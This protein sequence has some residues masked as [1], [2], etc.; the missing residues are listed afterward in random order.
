M[1]VGNVG[2]SK[3]FDYTV[4]GDAVNLGARLEGVNKHFSTKILIS[5]ATYRAAK[6]KIEVREIDLITVKGKTKPVRI[7]ELVAKKGKLTKGR[8]ELMKTFA[9][10]LVA[11]RAQKWVDAEKHFKTVLKL[12]KNDG[13]SKTYLARCKELAKAKLP[14]SWNGIYQLTEK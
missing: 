9:D 10:G 1:I 5:G 6:S 3:R 2:S 14:K 4:I 7:Y 12:D 11:Y 8:K 13:P